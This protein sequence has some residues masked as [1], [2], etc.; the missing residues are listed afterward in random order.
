M[1]IDGWNIEAFGALQNFVVDDLGDAGVVVILGDNESGKSTLAA[2]FE[3]M[4]YGFRP[5]SRDKHPYVR[6]DSQRAEGMLRLELSDGQVAEVHRRLLSAPKG[7]AT[8]TPRPPRRRRR[9]EQ[10]GPTLFEAG[11]DGASAEVAQPEAPATN[12][13]AVQVDIGNQPLTWVEAVPRPLYRSLHA[14]T[15]DDARELDQGTWEQ[16]EDRLLGGAHLPFLRPAREAI[17][18][19]SSQ[20]DALWRADNRGKPRIKQLRDELRTARQ[21]QSDARDR[22]RR[23]REIQRELS[24]VEAQSTEA[25]H[26]LER[27]KHDLARAQLAVRWRAIQALEQR[28]DAV[29]ADVTLPADPQTTRA[30]MLRRVEELDE[31]LDEKLRARAR[32]R[33]ET[34]PSDEAQA[35]LA[36]ADEISALGAVRGAHDQD[37]RDV[38]DLGRTATALDATFAERARGWFDGEIDT[39]LLESLDG[40]TL[41]DLAERVEHAER[42]VID[43]E[44]A[45]DAAQAAHRKATR[46]LDAL[47]SA[48][49]ERE[50]RAQLTKL[51]QLSELESLLRMPLFQRDVV[52]ARPGD[53]RTSRSVAI[54][55]VILGSVLAV[56]AVVFPA[57]EI[58]LSFVIAA[59]GAQFIIGALILVALDRRRAPQAVAS[60]LAQRDELRADLGINEGDTETAIDTAEDTVRRATWRTAIEREIASTSEHAAEAER[61]VALAHEARDKARSSFLSALAGWPLT[62]RARKAPTTALVAALDRVASVARERAE[63]QIRLDAASQRVEERR[64][65]ANALVARLDVAAGDE[66]MSPIAT[67]ARKLSDAQ[68]LAGRAELARRE[69]PEVDALI[70]KLDARKREATT[71]LAALETTLAELGDGERHDVAAIESGLA[72]AVAAI[73]ARRQARARREALDD[74]W[75]D[76]L[77]EGAE[78]IDE[79]ET[80]A[81]VA[82]LEERLGDLR[83]RR[84]SLEEERRTL[85]SLA[86]LDDADGALAALEDEITHV[87]RQRD[88][89][90]LLASLVREGDRRYRQEHQP[91]VVRRASR[92]IAALTGGRYTALDVESVDGRSRLRVVPAGDVYPRPVESAH[93][94]LSRGTREQIHLAFRLALA[95]HL[96]AA[97]PLPLLLDEMLMTWDPKRLDEGAARL[98]RVGKNRQVFVFTCQPELASRLSRAIGARI[99]KTPSL[100]PVAEAPSV[101]ETA[102]TPNE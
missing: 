48:E 14:L 37:L 15:L 45:H 42:T 91:D 77:A 38:D 82:E 41:S 63:A 46:Q 66:P 6:Q 9:R 19:A 58:L 57:D 8:I 81:A 27:R 10:T 20:A 102:P 65:R 13:A 26:E 40:A 34:E 23:L 30:E 16:V 89:W 32:H 51:R 54:A 96:D 60:P 43:V 59:I 94:P 33:A 68:Q 87:E 3:T 56:V 7:Q 78:E 71:E 99:V 17:D 93:R 36:E 12:A 100:P 22:H 44:R 95:E 50:S 84:G 53:Q 21:A 31:Q 64:R 62:D 47:P 1:R 90:A 35:L 85:G 73:D 69:L 29:L 88:R 25:R 5:A 97:E 80:T 61:A 24:D 55:L 2:F 101:A 11:A 92:D 4:L 52:D 86:T 39:A 49:A 72:H 98:G 79:L 74:G 18:E 67:L 70:E 83:H 28:A 75:E 76:M